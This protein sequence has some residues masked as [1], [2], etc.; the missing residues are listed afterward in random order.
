MQ[1]VRQ[2][3]PLVVV[4][5]YEFFSPRDDRESQRRRASVTA[6]VHPSLPAL[7]ASKTPSDGTALMDRFAWLCDFR[8]SVSAL[9]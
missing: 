5:H 7:R 3:L 1:V 6:L 4:W 2:R 8:V 9:G